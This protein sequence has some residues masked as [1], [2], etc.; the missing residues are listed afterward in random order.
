MESATVTSGIYKTFINGE[1][2]ESGSGKRFPVFDPSK[3]EVIAE[4]PDCDEGDVN[5]AVAAARVAFETWSQTTAQERG[6]LLFRLADYIRKDIDRLAEIESRN[7]G[8]P[9]V[10]AEYDVDVQ[11]S[12]PEPA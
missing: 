1:W 4:V 2:V 3:E 6:R 10:E 9:I 8:K 5:R 11:R 7:S 12:E